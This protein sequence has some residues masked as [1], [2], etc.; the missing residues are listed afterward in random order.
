MMYRNSAQT[1]PVEAHKVESLGMFYTSKK[2]GKEGVSAFLE[3]RQAVFTAK[4][5][6]DMPAFYPWLE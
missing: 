4:T 2:D 1:H 3:K 6:S 5:S